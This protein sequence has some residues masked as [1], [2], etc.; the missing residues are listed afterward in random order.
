MPSKSR[1]Q[2]RSYSAST[3]SNPSST[4]RVFLLCRLVFAVYGWNTNRN[5]TLRGY[6]HY[7]FLDAFGQTVGEFINVWDYFSFT[8]GFRSTAHAS[9]CR[10]TED[11]FMMTLTALLHNSTVR[12]LIT[13][14][15]PFRTRASGDFPSKFA[16]KSIQK[17]GYL[18]LLVEKKWISYP[19]PV[20]TV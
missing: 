16:G 15:F 11:V 4:G 19:P 18:I 8:P 12:I 2:E 17:S 1:L 7:S 9:P 3:G 5:N 13:S 20:M 6:P 14:N 10:P